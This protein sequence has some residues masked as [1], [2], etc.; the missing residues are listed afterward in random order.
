M[1]SIGLVLAVYLYKLYLYQLISAIIFIN[2]R[3]ILTHDERFANIIG[4]HHLD[5]HKYRVY[6]YG[7]H[8]LDYLFG[9]NI[10]NKT[11]LLENK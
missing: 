8:W 6:N 3:G 1:Q 11:K 9:T 5:H 4:D 7:E 10:S 2:V